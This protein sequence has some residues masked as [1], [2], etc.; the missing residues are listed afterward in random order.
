VIDYGWVARKIGELSGEYRIAG[1]KFDR[2]RIDDLRRELDAAGVESWVE[3]KDWSPDS[4]KMQPD[5]LRLVPHGQGFKDMNPAVSCIEDLL[6]EGRLRHG[7]HPVLTW[8]AS[9]TRIQSDPA[10]NRKFDKIKSTG[11]IDGLVAL[12]MALNGAVSADAVEPSVY[13][14]RGVIAL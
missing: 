10:A 9:N 11:R 6:L 2:W 1:I 5:G 8:C 13:E 7:M 14:T 3:G 12:A 4:N